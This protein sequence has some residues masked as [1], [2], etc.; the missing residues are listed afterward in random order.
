MDEW[1]DGMS[2]WED[3]LIIGWW[4]GRRGDVDDSGLNARMDGRLKDE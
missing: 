2:I 3:G 4:E 1:R